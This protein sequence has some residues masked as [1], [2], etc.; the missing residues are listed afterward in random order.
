MSLHTVLEEQ[1]IAGKLVGFRRRI[2]VA[3]NVV[4]V[5]VHWYAVYI[6]VLL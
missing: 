3:I 2:I 5:D 6:L 1:S 4:Y